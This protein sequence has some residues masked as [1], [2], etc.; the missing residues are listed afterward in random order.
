MGID[1]G[2]GTVGFGFLRKE[3]H[4][5]RAVK[6]GVIR[7][8]PGL[9]LGDR[10]LTLEADMNELLDAFKPDVL[11]IE[12]LF[13]N[14]NITTGIT[15]A[16]ARGVI[17]LAAAHH[18][19]PVYEY[20]P[21]SIKLAATGY[22]KATKSQVITM[23]QQLLALAKKPSPDDAADALAVALCHSFHAPWHEATSQ[24]NR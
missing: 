1:P 6:Y 3:G 16:H 20:N 10:L 2:I 11:A 4:A 9:P 7:T 22:G 17:L 8:T 21:A 15:V 14:K 19:V 24:S 13:F 23:T 5:L 12:E 18:H